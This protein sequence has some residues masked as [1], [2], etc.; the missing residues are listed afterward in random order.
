[1]SLS[2]FLLFL[3][4]GSGGFADFWIADW[5]PLDAE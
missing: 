1:V 5:D 3:V 2:F 4:F